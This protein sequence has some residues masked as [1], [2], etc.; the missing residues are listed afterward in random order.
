M[1]NQDIGQGIGQSVRRKEDFRFITGQGNY[2]D[3]INRPGQL[4]AGFLRSP[5]AFAK[6]K[7][8]S[9]D[10]A[11]KMPGVIAVYTGKDVAADKVGSLICGWVVKDKKGEPHK[12]PRH[13][14]IA[15][16][17]VRHVGDQ[18]AAVIAETASQAR[19]AAERIEVEYEV[20]Q[21]VTDIRDALKPGA[22]QI[23]AE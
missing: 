10:A 11:R 23:H 14:I 16:D 6:I 5:H 18:V 1:S 2:T 9:T 12:A 19:D 22:P 21:S 4:Y 3:D 15:V 17:H 13:D 7:S 8:I 20:L